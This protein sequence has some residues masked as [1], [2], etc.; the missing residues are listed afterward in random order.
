MTGTSVTQKA[1]TLLGCEPFY[2]CQCLATLVI[3]GRFMLPPKALAMTVIFVGIIVL[4]AFPS[5]QAMFAN[6]GIGVTGKDMSAM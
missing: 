4:H 1:R 6:I 3:V 2:L 5:I